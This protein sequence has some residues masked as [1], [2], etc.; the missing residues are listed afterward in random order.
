ML[1]N[2]TVPIRRSSPPT[3]IP[4]GAA[5]NGLFVN[6]SALVAGGYPRSGVVSLI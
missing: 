4:T 1:T 3:P 5:A 2:V 6:K